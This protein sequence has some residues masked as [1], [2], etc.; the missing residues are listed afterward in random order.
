MKSVYQH[1]KI[2]LFSSYFLAVIKQNPLSR[3][4]IYTEKYVTEPVKVVYLK[5]LTFK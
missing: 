4:N 1:I 2:H 3:K 5:R